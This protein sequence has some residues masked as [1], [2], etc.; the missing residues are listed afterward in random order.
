MQNIRDLKDLAIAIIESAGAAA[1]DVDPGTTLRRLHSLADAAR[2]V[3]ANPAGD[4]DRTRSTLEHVRATLK[5]R[6]IDEATDD[7]VD[8][9][10]QMADEALARACA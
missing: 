10:L 4:S 3:L 7:E 8:E 1:E 6:H 9:A 2:K 5:L